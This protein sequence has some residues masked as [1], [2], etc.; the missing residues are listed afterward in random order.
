VSRIP[1]LYAWSNTRRVVGSVGGLDRARSWRRHGGGA[2]CSSRGFGRQVW[3]L[4]RRVGQGRE[5]TV[6]AGGVQ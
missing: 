5:K 2:P 1:S 4:Y 6:G 3:H